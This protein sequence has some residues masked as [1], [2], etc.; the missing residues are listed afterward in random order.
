MTMHVGNKHDYLGVDLELEQDGRL[1]VSMVNY[2][3]NVIKAFPEQIVGRA[4]TPGGERLFDIRDE[5]EGKPL[6]E[7][8]AIAFHHTT[9]QLL[10]MATRA[11]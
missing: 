10:F 7:K 3:K 6:Y 8:H 11:R 1:D 4:A 2:L 5:K 9:V